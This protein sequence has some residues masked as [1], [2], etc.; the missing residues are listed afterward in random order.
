MTHLHRKFIPARPL[1]ID[2]SRRACVRKQ[3]KNLSRHKSK[4]ELLWLEVALIR[5]VDDEIC[6]AFRNNSTFVEFVDKPH[7]WVIIA[8]KRLRVASC[9]KHNQKAEIHSGIEWE[10]KIFPV[11][12]T[13]QRKIFPLNV[14]AWLLQLELL[15]NHRRTQK[16]ARH[17][18]WDVNFRHSKDDLDSTSLKLSA[19]W[20][21]VAQIRFAGVWMIFSRF[22]LL[23][24]M[25]MLD[26]S[27]ALRF[28]YIRLMLF[29]FFPPCLTFVVQKNCFSSL[30][31]INFTTFL[32]LSPHDKR[33]KGRKI[34]FNP[35]SIFVLFCVA[36]FSEFFF[37]EQMSFGGLVRMS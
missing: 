35:K 11:I 19:I 21:E 17:L 10:K 27:E 33:K 24:F 2:T 26:S 15:L 36:Q 25:M 5:L 30:S 12:T 32:S 28:G 22:S 7:R 20:S 3:I 1:E 29:I 4:D 8:T 16:P 14:F 13:W 34:I 9:Y 37:L 18:F 23:P 31:M 6:L